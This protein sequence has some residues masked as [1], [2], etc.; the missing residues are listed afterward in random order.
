MESELKENYPDLNVKLIK[1][2]G[3]I[4]EV[5]YNGK[6]IFSKKKTEEQ[7]FPQSGEIA[8]L[9]KQEIG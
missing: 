1:G 2:S 3:G 9:F 7:R 5:T 8:A 6:L 4:F